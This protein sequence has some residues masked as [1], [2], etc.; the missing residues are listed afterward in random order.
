MRA[1]W[2][3]CSKRNDVVDDVETV[4]V[5]EC[6]V[7]SC[8]GVP[9]PGAWPSEGADIESDAQWVHVQAEASR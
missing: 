2:R 5:G 1:G 6:L 7:H 8:H 3:S 9:D 4:D